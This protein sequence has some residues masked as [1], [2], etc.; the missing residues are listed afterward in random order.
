MDAED[1]TTFALDDL[2]RRMEKTGDQWIAVDQPIH[3]A[4]H[5]TF[6]SQLYASDGSG[7]AEAYLG[8]WLA[9]RLR[10][11][12]TPLDLCPSHGLSESQAAAARLVLSSPVS[13]LYGGP[14]T[15]K[16]Y[17]AREIVRALRKAE[18]TVQG[19]AFTGAAASRLGE[20]TG[21][22]C[23]TLHKSL[24]YRPRRSAGPV[25]AEEGDRAGVFTVS[26]LLCDAL[27]IDEGSFLGPAL[28][29]AAARRLRPG[30]RLILIG[31]PNQ[32]YSPEPGAL[33]EQ[34]IQVAPA[35]ALTEIRRT[36][37]DSP[38][39][40][41]AVDILAGR[42]PQTQHAEGNGFA[43][44]PI[45]HMRQ[46]RIGS[47]GVRPRNHPL[48]TAEHLA[49]IGAQPLSSVATMAATNRTCEALNEDFFRH[50]RER[51]SPAPYMCIRNTIDEESGE[52]VFNGDVGLW[53]GSDGEDR[54]LIDF[55]NGPVSMPRP[56][57]KPA[58]CR[59][60]HKSQGK[61][62]DSAQYIAEPSSTR[63][64]VYTAVTR[65]RKRVLLLGTLDNISRA[66]TTTEAPRV[67]LLA[68]FV[69]EQAR[70]IECI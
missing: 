36:D 47:D 68:S 46:M 69:S 49:E 32:L 3:G 39:G 4:Q 13:C 30:A 1:P 26:E 67:G 16:T 11:D 19:A 38:I 44:I 50:R 15:G 61:E 23:R 37:K 43:L 53:A 65:G 58:W 35:A 57:L 51:R 8:A 27:V 5:A 31:D 6:G 59:T 14:G 41:A 40:Q 33:Y 20:L 28:L 21:L 64:A 10:K 66:V 29:L 54:L 62:Y 9:A 17:T 55:G 63:R 52:Y 56:S 25:P 18:L 12:A 48:Q 70:L 60:A 24:G 34:I 2:R 7:L 42:V 22:E 45:E